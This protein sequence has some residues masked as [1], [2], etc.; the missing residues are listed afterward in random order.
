MRSPATLNSPGSP[1]LPSGQSPLPC[2]PG[3]RRTTRCRQ[4]AQSRPPPLSPY[5]TSSF[6]SPSVDPDFAATSL[7]HPRCRK[8]RAQTQISVFVAFA[9]PNIRLS[10]SKCFAAIL[11]LKACLRPAR[12]RTDADILHAILGSN[13]HKGKK[14]CRPARFSRPRTRLPRRPIQLDV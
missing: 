12:A 5:A 10:K 1:L 13:Q 4:A 14:S 9:L 6:A 2:S 7:S 11:R 3:S 8:N